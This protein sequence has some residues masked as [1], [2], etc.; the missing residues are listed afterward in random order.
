MKVSLIRLT[1]R[2]TNPR[3]PCGGLLG[4]SL[5]GMCEGLAVS[6]AYFRNAL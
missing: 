2:D 6:A 1:T 3:M 4:P 5:S